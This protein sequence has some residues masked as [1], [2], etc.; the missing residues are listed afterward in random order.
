[1]EIGKRYPFLVVLDFFSL[2]T[3]QISYLLA[4]LIMLDPENLKKKL[5]GKTEVKAYFRLWAH[6]FCVSDH[7]MVNFT[8]TSTKISETDAD[9]QIV[10]SEIFK[11]N[12]KRAN[13]VLVSIVGH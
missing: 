7:R 13:K 1:M 11:Y 2:A 8:I 3:G 5:G 12:L 10:S 9:N 6:F 4:K